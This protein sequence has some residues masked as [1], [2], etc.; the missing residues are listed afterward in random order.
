MKA[1]NMLA[2]LGSFFKFGVRSKLL[3]SFALVGSLTVIAALIGI[4]SLWKLNQNFS[5][6][7][8]NDLPEFVYSAQLAT[9]TTGLIVATN[10]VVNADD[11][12]QKNEALGDL[13][14]V[15]E[16]FIETVNAFKNIA[17]DSAS[18]EGLQS[19]ANDFKSN[20]KSLDTN[21]SDR[22]KSE[23]K[24]S[25]ELSKL[26]NES[27]A[28]TEVFNSKITDAELVLRIGRKGAQSRSKNVIR[29]ITQRE[30]PLVT[31]LLNLKIT[32]NKI[33]AK[34]VG[35]LFATDS[36]VIRELSENIKA[37]EENVNS[38]IKSIRK[39]KLS[40]TTKKQ[41]NDFLERGKQARQLYANTSEF[42]SNIEKRQIISQLSDL[43]QKNENSLL[44]KV[45]Q[46][47]EKLTGVASKSGERLAKTIDRLL[48]QEVGIL[49]KNLT[50]SVRLNQ[51]VALLIQGALQENLEEFSRLQRKISEVAN[52]FETASNEIG[53]SD[54]TSSVPSLLAYSDP[55]SGLL[56][57]RQKEITAI[58]QA[59]TIVKEFLA[60][61]NQIEEI[62]K[63]LISQSETL[64]RNNSNLISAEID[65][66][67]ILL[68]IVVGLSILFILAIVIFVVNK[69]LVA[70]LLNIVSSIKILASGETNVDICMSGRNDEIGDLSRALEVFK[71][72]AVERDKL[73]QLEKEEQ[74]AQLERQ[75]TLEQL[76][77]DFRESVQSALVSMSNNAD[78]M[79]EAAKALN[80]NVIKT[81]SEA[82]KASEASKVASVNVQTVGS[83]AEEMT[84]SIS[85]I[86]RQ[87]VDVNSIVEQATKS[88]N[89]TNEK[90]TGLVSAAENVG[91]VVKLISEIAEK[92]N[93]LALNATIEAARAGESGRGFAVVAT[94]VKSL[95]NQTA[96]ATEEIGVQ[97]AK[98]Q[99]ATTDS[100]S[101]IE[102]ITK[103]ITDISQYTFG[104]SSAVEEQ[105]AATSEI[106]ANAE[107]A[108]Q[109]TSNVENAITLVKSVATKT[110]GS[111]DNLYKG[112]T[113]VN[114]EAK[115]LK[116]T[117]D[118]FLEHVSRC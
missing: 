95:A 46:Q 89:S 91:D 16:N 84:S 86:G 118:E 12:N 82:E 115:Q 38:I 44:V 1:H 109:R 10:N 21:I 30:M 24:R 76:I 79:R 5:H 42:S 93:L 6:L 90:M 98:I 108:S 29:R 3:L 55:Q 18:I 9:L 111:A 8:A 41:I 106:A 23:E 28:L 107:E 31:G 17:Q 51:Y 74:A 19:I 80:D 27:E 4:Y 69:G 26:F 103:T 112:A 33:Y 61:S 48:T 25:A 54:I 58:K 117:V 94:E 20:I 65:R 66:S 81:S 87:V 36:N 75:Q 78:G 35:L 56:A 11:T 59:D 77:S 34:T 50:A 88:A 37:N 32:L 63:K 70:P 2:T 83:A 102:L 85:E 39:V 14:Q 53:S 60:K 49:R 96:K 13:N 15:T 68:S 43:H 101:A 110:Q 71:S 47:Q 57:G 99:D 113:E 40:E 105:G 64:V 104:V 22:I 73:R 45:N 67:K 116:N 97:I 52:Q 100:V 62:V 92:T 7:A 114:N 72:N